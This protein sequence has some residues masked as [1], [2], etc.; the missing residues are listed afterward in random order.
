MKK[1]RQK[2]ELWMT[3]IKLWNPRRRISCR[4][5]LCGHLDA[6]KRIREKTSLGITDTIIAR[7]RV[8]RTV[9]INIRRKLAIAWQTIDA[10]TPAPDALITDTTFCYMLR[11]LAFAL[12]RAEGG[13]GERSVQS[14]AFGFFVADVGDAVFLLEGDLVPV[15]FFQDGSFEGIVEARGEVGGILGRR[16]CLVACVS[17]CRRGSTFNS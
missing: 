3:L 12:L 15:L 13:D 7:K 2:K 10:I 6:L 5:S 4:Q 11:P 16:L 9:P 8:L 17:I 14:P 1:T